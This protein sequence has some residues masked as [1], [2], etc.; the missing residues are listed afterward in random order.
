M[1]KLDLKQ[2]ILGSK[3]NAGS[4]LDPPNCIKGTSFF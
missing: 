4:A 2:S 1:V 3:Y